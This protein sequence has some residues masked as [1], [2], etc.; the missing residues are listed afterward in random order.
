MP[1][2][3]VTA[4]TTAVSVAAD[5]VDAVVIP[6]SMTIDNDGGSADR[7]IRIQDVFTPAATD[8]TG[9]PSETTVDRFRITAPVGDIITLSEEDL[10]GVKCLGALMVIGDAVDAACFISVGYKH[11]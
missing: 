1:S 6:T 8:G 5:R 10:K 9:S 7:T 4:H 2:L 3:V 11:E